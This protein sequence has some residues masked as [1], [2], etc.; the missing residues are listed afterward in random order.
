MTTRL[1]GGAQRTLCGVGH[2]ENTNPMT[3]LGALRNEPRAQRWE[4]N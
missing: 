3:L 1:F 2:S 4:A